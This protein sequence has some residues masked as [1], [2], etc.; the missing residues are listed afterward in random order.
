MQFS[1]KPPYNDD[2]FPYVWPEDRRT[3]HMSE[4]PLRSMFS[5]G[6]GIALVYDPRSKFDRAQTNPTNPILDDFRSIYHETTPTIYQGY[7][8]LAE[9]WLE[10]L[11]EDPAMVKSINWGALVDTVTGSQIDHARRVLNRLASHD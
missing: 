10:L 8:E 3:V 4:G 9:I 11:D 5:E 7:W 1:S 6:D 2:P